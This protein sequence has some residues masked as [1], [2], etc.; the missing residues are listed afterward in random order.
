MRRLLSFST[1][2]VAIAF[3]SPALAQDQHM[4]GMTMP[5]PAPSPSATSKPKAKSRPKPKAL[6]PATARPVATP[7]HH[8]ARP[9]S[10]PSAAARQNPSADQQTIPKMTGMEHSQMK[11]H[12]AAD[13]AAAKMPDMDHSAMGHMQRMGNH[14]EAPTEPTPPPPE[15]G[16]G[17]ARAADSIWGAEAMRASR[18]QLRSENGGQT[19]AKVLID[20]LEYKAHEGK[21]GY[22]W[23]GQAWYGGD[24]D[25]LV[26]RSEGEGTFGGKAERAEVQA[27]WGHA[28][29]PWFDLQAG[30]RHDFV[31]PTRTYAVV[32][33]QG[34]AP[35]QFE[36]SAQAFLSTKGEL[37][38]RIE[39][40][41]DQ[42]ITQR[43]ILQPRA[44]LNLAAQDIPELGIGAGLDRA[45][46]GLR[47]RYE[48]AREFAP[49]VG[50]AQ[51]WKV[52]GSADYA[53]AR[54]DSASTTSLV[55]GLRAWF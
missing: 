51:E 37:T 23:E 1:A 33:V 15:A 43:L 22:A 24:I 49:Y 52:G 26:V 19:F 40:E 13:E 18:E 53:H 50:I 20:R 25:K 4:H 38:A 47:L 10:S 35:Y 21:D 48:F 28:I 32:G 55:I 11:H 42:R 30:A 27:L 7:S 44:E 36:T 8:T 29:G 16:T 14:A 6:A 54:G 39:G 3:A 5:M 17:P 2:A 9:K 46:V 34:L 41:L 12:G 31:G 45:E